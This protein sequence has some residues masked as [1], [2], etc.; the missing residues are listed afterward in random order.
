MRARKVQPTPSVQYRKTVWVGQDKVKL[1]RPAVGV[2][3]LLGQSCPGLELVQ[4]L[5]SKGEV[6]LVATTPEA[7]DEAARYIKED[8]I[9]FPV[10]ERER[11]CTPRQ[12]RQLERNGS[13]TL[14]A[15]ARSTAAW[16]CLDTDNVLHLVG[17]ER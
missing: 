14:D 16:L 4:D 3:L 8:F 11:L 7:L 13:S 2:Q 12:A 10:I 9:D 15:I 6:L 17:T 5:P 1:F